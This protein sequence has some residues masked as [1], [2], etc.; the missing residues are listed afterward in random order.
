M[1]PSY[2]AVT[3]KPCKK[4]ARTTRRSCH[5]IH[6]QPAKNTG[7]KFQRPNPYWLPP[8]RARGPHLKRGLPRFRQGIRVPQSPPLLLKSPVPPH[9]PRGAADWTGTAAAREAQ[10]I[11][12]VARTSRLMLSRPASVRRIRL[13]RV[14]MLISRMQAESGC[15]GGCASGRPFKLAPCPEMP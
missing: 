11:D 10:P 13:R 1:Y 8:A 4:T 5:L 14:P 15:A 3:H 9:G 6:Q 2:P 12:R 7:A